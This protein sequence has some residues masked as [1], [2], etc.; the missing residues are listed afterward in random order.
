MPRALKH[1]GSGGSQ[2]MRMRWER[3]APQPR[4]DPR[5]Y[6]VVQ[7]QSVTTSEQQQEPVFEMSDEMRE[8]LKNV[9]TSEKPDEQQHDDNTA[10]DKQNM[11]LTQRRYNNGIDL[12]IDT[13]FIP[14]LH[15]MWQFCGEQ[16]DSIA[17]ITS[18]RSQHFKVKNCL[19]GHSVLNSIIESRGAHPVG[20]AFMLSGF[21]AGSYMS[22]Y[23][24]E[25]IRNQRLTFDDLSLIFY[26]IRKRLY[27]STRAQIHL[28]KNA[29]KSLWQALFNRDN[30]PIFRFPRAFLAYCECLVA[31]VDA[32]ELQDTR[33]L[34]GNKQPS[35]IDE[36]IRLS[37]LSSIFENIIQDSAQAA[38]VLEEASFK[39]PSAV[40]VFILN[41]GSYKKRYFRPLGDELPL[42]KDQFQKYSGVIWYIMIQYAQSLETSSDIMNMIECIA[43]YVASNPS[44]WPQEL[45]QEVIKKENSVQRGYQLLKDGVNSDAAKQDSPL[46]WMPPP[47]LGMTGLLQCCVRN[48]K[49]D[50]CFSVFEFMLQ[51]KCRPGYQ[52][53]HA[54]VTAA[55]RKDLRLYK[56][57]LKWLTFTP[58]LPV[59]DYT[60]ISTFGMACK[61][62]NIPANDRNRIFSQCCELLGHPSRELIYSY[63]RSFDAPQASPMPFVELFILTTQ[64]V[65]HNRYCQP[66]VA[67][68]PKHFVLRIG[69]P[70]V[71]TA[72]TRYFTFFGKNRNLSI[73]NGIIEDSHDHWSGSNYEERLV[74][75][76]KVL[77]PTE[78]LD[79]NAST[80]IPYTSILN[81]IDAYLLCGFDISLY[82]LKPFAIYPTIDKSYSTL[83]L[84]SSCLLWCDEEYLTTLGSDNTCI[85]PVSEYYK[86]LEFCEREASPV[87]KQKV[88]SVAASLR[89]AIQSTL[90]KTVWEARDS[91]RESMKLLGTEKPEMIKSLLEKYFT[92]LPYEEELKLLKGFDGRDEEA[93]PELASSLQVSKVAVESLDVINALHSDPDSDIEVL[94]NASELATDWAT[95]S[96]YL[97][98]SQKVYSPFHNERDHTRQVPA[99]DELLASQIPDLDTKITNR[100]RWR[101]R[102]PA[103]PD[104]LLQNLPW[105]S[106]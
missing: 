67:G 78:E 95:Q 63:L 15:F 91:C 53:V 48:N 31:M 84:H 60:I 17:D 83:L 57:T 24:M 101:L 40:V 7:P 43:P 64:L 22:T 94:T 47:R 75:D 2:L 88:E 96:D 42:P 71:V 98:R 54:V 46:V 61:G 18:L 69:S 93:F 77:F 34:Y 82:N 55:V 81:P 105:D 80:H 90:G 70:E 50:T 49:F 21:G 3:V 76:K 14:W 52:D 1:L 16:E 58:E 66:N 92:L 45:L 4:G 30:H 6:K 29:L 51:Q 79:E 8:A 35:D 59:S 87:T 73:L 9:D 26:S 97:K 41:R 62:G 33:S 85:L 23:K 37:S 20:I 38:K 103:G 102:R 89:P 44:F 13:K 106:D 10:I 56:N 12:R 39:N 28:E 68:K 5:V 27:S 74:N 11:F 86:F 72:A 104:S 32:N 99:F 65:V 25:K 19:V 36:A 100:F